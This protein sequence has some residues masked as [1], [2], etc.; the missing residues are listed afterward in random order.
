MKKIKYAA[1]GGGTAGII[2]IGALKAFIE[3]DI[4]ISSIIGVSAGAIFGALYWHSFL[5]NNGDTTYIYDDMY[6]I[7]MELNFKDFAD[8]NWFYRSI[9]SMSNN[10]GKS[11]LYKGFALSKWLEDKIGNIKF[12]DLPMDSLFVTATEM[13]SGTLTVFSKQTTPDLTLAEAVRASS[14]IQGYFRPATIQFNKIQD[15]FFS[16]NRFDVANKIL[17][18]KLENIV[19]DDGNILFWDGG[20][21]GNCRN[22]IAVKIWDQSTTVVGVSLTEDPKLEIQKFNIFGVL[23]KTIDIMMSS[24]EN[25]VISLSKAHSDRPDYLIKP[26]RF[27]VGA[28]EFDI[29]DTMKLKLIMSGYGETKKLIEEKL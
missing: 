7:F 22:D 15:A 5:K 11:G 4:Q 28:A 19:N 1:G 23:S 14:S 25:V 21:L 27:G 17:P 2:H 6:E 9:L 29:E 8:T 16:K 20:N 24:M 18:N 3:N 10:P 13:Y 12:K 26:D